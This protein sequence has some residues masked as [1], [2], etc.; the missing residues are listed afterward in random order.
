MPLFY[1]PWGAPGE[2]ALCSKVLLVL[3]Y[4]SAAREDVDSDTL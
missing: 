2:T 4:V 1:V 3:V